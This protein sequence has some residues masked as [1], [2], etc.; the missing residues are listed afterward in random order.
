MANDPTS[1][2]SRAADTPAP[3]NRLSRAGIERFLEA[4]SET[5]SVCESLRRAG[6]PRASVYRRRARDRKFA[7]DWEEALSVGLDLLRDE[8]LRRAVDGVERPVFHGG[9]QIGRVRDTSDR[10]LMFL[11]QAHRPEIYRA[12]SPAETAAAKAETGTESKLR[13]AEIEAAKR[14]GATEALNEL[15]REIE[16]H[17]RAARTLRR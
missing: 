16:E 2:P 14:E 4:L 6:V 1:P 7:A 5:A 11:L 8:A 10:L 3:R 12:P 13:A 15:F 9:A 17:D